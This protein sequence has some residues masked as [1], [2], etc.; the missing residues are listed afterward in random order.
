MKDFE[1]YAGIDWASEKHL[2]CLLDGS[3]EMVEQRECA[4]DG[5]GLAEL[6]DWLIAKTRAEPQK[7]AVAI[8]TPR[9]PIVETLV[10]RGFAIFSIN[11]KQLDRFRDRFTVAGAKDDSRD[12]EV[13]GHSLMT[14]RRAFRRLMADDPVIVELREWSRL[15]EDLQ[16]E[17]IRLAN[18]M[19]QQLWRY[20]PQML[21]LADDP[22]ADW[23]LELWDLVAT[24]GEAAKV[25]EAF[26]ARFLK[27]HRIRRFGAGEALGILRQKPLTVAPGTVEAATAHIRIIAARIRLVNQQIKQANRKLD[28]LCRQIEQPSE[29]DAGN[30]PEQRDVAILRSLP[31]IG[32]IILATL[33]AEACEPLKRR[34]YHI[35]RTV[36][37][38]APVTRR[39]GKTCIVVRRRACNLRLANA[40]YHW[41]RVA[42]QHDTVSQ[43]RYAALRQR[44]HSHGRALRTVGDRLLE[45]A[46]TLLRRQV[47]FDPHYHTN[48]RAAAA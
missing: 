25:S 38:Q 39:S 41:A 37:G 5:S 43:Q 15:S 14:D 19:R 32:R 23:L 8:E 17:R 47:L 27:S 9:G 11:P 21:K 40:L 1:W 13:L 26:L 18:R 29:N 4:H 12:A 20:Y 36:S 45:L 3:G 48:Q 46:C 7:I 31:G 42:I 16:Q 44:G 22:A 30:R 6:C 24:P 35:L 28:A 2:V 33:L 10:E 34:D